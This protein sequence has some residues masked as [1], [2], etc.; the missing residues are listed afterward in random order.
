MNARLFVNTRTRLQRLRDAK[1]VS[2]W[3]REIT[4]TDVLV[5][6]NEQV[7]VAPGEVFSFQV[8]GKGVSALFKGVVKVV[9]GDRDLLFSIQP[10]IR[11]QKQSENVR[12]MVDG[13][14]G[15]VSSGDLELEVLVMDLS[16]NGA[17]ILLSTSLHKGEKVQLRIDSPHGQIVCAAEVKYCR[18]DG[19]MPGQYRAGMLIAPENRVDLAR[20]RRLLDGDVAA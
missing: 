8:H 6:T 9:S 11:Y 1:L 14:T 17:G 18:R 10:P 7:A 3:V 16:E 19:Q 15:L 12:I 4:G 2:G 13:M 20:W 5:Q